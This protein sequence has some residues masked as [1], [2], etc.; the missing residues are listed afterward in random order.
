MYAKNT[1]GIWYFSV[2][3]KDLTGKVVQKTVQ[4]KDWGKKEAKAAEAA[5]LLELDHGIDKLTV[6]QL[7]DLYL[8][9]RLHKVKLKSTYTMTSAYN[10]HI[11]KQ[12]GDMV[13][14]KITPRQI[15]AWQTNLLDHGYRNKYLV[16][17][18]E[19]LKTIFNFGVN[20]G[21]IERSPFR[22]EFVRNMNEEKEEML[23]WT[24][25]EF[26]KFIDNVD[27]PVYKA[28]F[29][30]LYWSGLR[31]G[32]AIALTPKDINFV[33]NTIRVSK[34]YDSVNKVT[35]TPKTQNSYRT[36]Q[37][38]STLRSVLNDLCERNKK[39]EDF[40]EDDLVFGCFDHLAPTSI[41]RAQ[42]KACLKSGVKIIRIHDF[43]HS[44]VSMLVNM[45]FNTFEI[46]KR[47]GHTV[48][49]VE[50]IY[51]HWYQMSQEEMV[52]RL[53]QAA[54]EADKEYRKLHPLN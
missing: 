3:Y 40:T 29:T 45:G 32:E 30:T 53:D 13:I 50:N 8:Q 9:N 28:F 16:K 34:T 38:T 10:L 44:H 52:R 43:R 42:V 18:Q 54:E 31:E 23:Y 5:Y 33:N 49:M 22:G 39:V 21:Y 25:P 27:D 20:Y 1:K 47:M 37:M 36:V 14:S 2:R 46:A 6:N 15:L 41:K 51:G 11:R 19:Y 24:M 7:A 4:N 35:T 17:I 26:T 12:L 48:A